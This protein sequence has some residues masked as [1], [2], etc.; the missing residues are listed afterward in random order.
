MTDSRKTLTIAGGGTSPPE[1]GAPVSQ[2][3]FLTPFAF[4]D[5]AAMAERQALPDPRGAAVHCRLAA[6][7]MVRWLYDNDSELKWPYQDS[8]AA[9]IAEPSFMR[10]AGTMIRWK[11][12]H[13][14]APSIRPAS[15]RSSRRAAPRPAP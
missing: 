2:F 1:D 9:L 15:R 14:E 11:I 10:L 12:C 3:V 5:H 8:L 4:H 7:A 6:E 13:S